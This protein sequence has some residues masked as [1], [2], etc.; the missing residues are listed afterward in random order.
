MVGL[1]F[2][3]GRARPRAYLNRH[4]SDRI[5]TIGQGV[6]G[7]VTSQ[8]PESRCS[9]VPLDVQTTFIPWL[10]LGGRATTRS[11]GPGRVAYA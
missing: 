3:V 11:E 2:Y 7:Y 5:T 10:R 4:W 1:V 9:G 6:R 8:A